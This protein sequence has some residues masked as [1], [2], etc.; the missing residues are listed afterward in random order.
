SRRHK[1]NR[2]ALYHHPTGT[3][4]LRTLDSDAFCNALS[5]L[6]DGRILIVGGTIQYNPFRGS[7]N[8]TIFDPATERF[9]RVQDMARGR[10]YPSNATLADGR[11]MVFSGITDTGT[12]NND[13]EMY[14]VAVGWSRPATAPFVPPLY[15]WLHLLP[16][17]KIFFSGSTPSSAI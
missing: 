9:I 16:N 7:K 1:V 17:G 13:V 6:S 5:P 15:P 12:F 8:T 2:G 14:D 10:W 3:F 11:T 4:N